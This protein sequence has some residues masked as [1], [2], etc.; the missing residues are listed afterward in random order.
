MGGEALVLVKARCRNVGELKGGEAGV[1]GLVVEHPHRS[2][3]RDDRLGGIVG[4]QER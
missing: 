2:K 1:G 4:D 3:G